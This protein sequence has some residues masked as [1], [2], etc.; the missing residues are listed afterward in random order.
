MVNEKPE[1]YS[2]EFLDY[3][4]SL[5]EYDEDY[6][7]YMRFKEVECSDNE[8]NYIHLFQEY[9]S[10]VDYESKQIANKSRSTPQ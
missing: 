5:V 4:D 9:F 8:D 2:E 1:T 3:L 6:L 7:E 10:G